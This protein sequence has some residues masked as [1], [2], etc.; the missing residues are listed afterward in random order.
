M[1]GR[2]I[3]N[4]EYCIRC[5][6]VI[7]EGRQVC[8]NC[9]KDVYKMGKAKMIGMFKPCIPNSKADG[10]RNKPFKGARKKGGKHGK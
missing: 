3:M 4:E 2:K 10:R 9:E 8:P 1:H 5:G 7:P 6:A